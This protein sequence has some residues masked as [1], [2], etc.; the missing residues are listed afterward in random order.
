MITEIKDEVLLG[1]DILR[2][3]PVGPMDILNSENVMIFKGEWIPLHIVDEPRHKIKLFAVNT[4]VIPGKT[5][6]IVDGYLD[7]SEEDEWAELCM[8]VK[9]DT[10]FKQRHQCLVAPD[11]VDVAGQATTRD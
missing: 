1:D 11:I 6:K 7:W 4:M 9:A 5:E 8:L 10:W 3:D 2:R